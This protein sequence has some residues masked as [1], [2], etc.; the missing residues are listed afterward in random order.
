MLIAIDGGCKRQGTPQCSS[1]GV[2]WIQT[3]AGDLFY[4]ARYENLESTNQRGEL[5]GLVSAL[6]AALRYAEALEPI[7]IVT[8]SEYLYN[9][10][11]KGWSFTWERSDWQGSAGPV[12]NR[13][14]WKTINDLLRELNKKEERV[15]MQWTK[16]HLMSY[17]AGNIKKAMTAD[18][19]GIGLF[20]NLKSIANRPAE[21]DRIISDFAYNR[22]K[23]QHQ[24][25]PP[26]ACLDWCVANVM[27]DALAS[28]LI[29]HFD[30]V[31]LN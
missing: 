26:V 16:G 15:F 25:P 3:D 18:P 11:T 20:M 14:L 24:V 7:I 6:D 17:S 8:D 21:R 27:A 19:T 30:N 12:K 10:V 1:V 5:N 23:H 4:R 9:S 22:A 13:D 28:Y 31:A 2:A 29:A